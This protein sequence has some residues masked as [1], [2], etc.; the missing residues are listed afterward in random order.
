MLRLGV[1]W[2]LQERLRGG[3]S[4]R[5]NGQLV[6]LATALSNGEDFSPGRTVSLKSGSRLVREWRGETHDVIVIDNGFRWRGEI[7]Q[8]L[9]AI[10]REITGT[11]WSGPRFFGVAS[12]GRRGA[13]D[14]PSNAAQTGGTGDGETV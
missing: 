4:R 2:K 1:A 13:L 8:S 14:K 10:A 9:S 6:R 12:S 3:H 11:R 7:W 5:V